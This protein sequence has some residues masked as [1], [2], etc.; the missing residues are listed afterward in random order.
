MPIHKKGQK[1]D[2]G[3]YSLTSVPGQVMKQIIPSV[4]TWHLQDRQGIRPSQPGFRRDRSC[5]TNLI[6][7]Y[8]WVTCLVDEGKAVDVLYL[9][10]SKSFD[11]VSHSILL[12]KLAAH[13]LDSKFADDTKVGES[14]HLLEGR[15]ALQRELDRLDRWAKSNGMRFNKTKCRILHFSHN[16]ALQRYRLGT[17]WLESSQAER[18]LEVLIDRE[19]DMIQRCAQVAKKANGILACIRNSEASGSR[20]VSLHLYSVLVRSHLEY[21]PVLDSSI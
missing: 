14:V 4:I 8:D 15:R 21:C 10:F 6:S 13:S 12:E 7:V 3:N 18:D 5:L 20:E 19:L 9:H 2:L 11:T 1:E 17:E 16:N